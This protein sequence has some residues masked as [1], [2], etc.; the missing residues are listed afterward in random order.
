MI[1]RTLLDLHPQ[2]PEVITDIRDCNAMHRRVMSMFRHVR[3]DRTLHHILYRVDDDD[4]AIRLLVHSN[5][6]PDTSLIPLRYV[7]DTP[8]PDQ[9]YGVL[10][11]TGV[12]GSHWQFRLTTMPSKRDIATGKRVALHGQAEQLAWMQRKAAEHGF[13]ITDC[14]VTPH[15]TIYGYGSLARAPIQYRPVTFTGRLCMQD[16]LLVYTGV[17]HGIGTGKAYGLGLLEVY[18]DAS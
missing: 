2:H 11:Q 8:R 12:A 18:A 3:Y 15:P 6:I 1:I 14:S 4:G 9:L 17:Q 7:R 5:V 10:L 13:A 16:P